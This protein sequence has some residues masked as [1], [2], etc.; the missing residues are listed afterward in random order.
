MTVMTWFS[1]NI[2][3][4]VRHHN[5]SAPNS[6]PVTWG[7]WLSNLSS[8][9]LG[10][11]SWGSPLFLWGLFWRKGQVRDFTSRF[12][13]V[14]Q[15]LNLGVEKVRFSP[16]WRWPVP[17]RGR[18]SF[19][20]LFWLFRVRFVSDSRNQRKVWKVFVSHT[21]WNLPP[22]AIERPLIQRGGQL[23]RHVFFLE[24]VL[25]LNHPESAKDHYRLG[26]P[27]D[28]SVILGVS[29]PYLHGLKASYKNLADQRGAR[30]DYKWFSQKNV[31]QQCISK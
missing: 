16:S 15:I 19:R 6:T 30:A 27:R 26:A 9:E 28:G 13:C 3:P 17:F 14:S 7:G 8:G 4:F 1:S 11:K 23:G 24:M 18:A 25:H 22:D 29:F 10:Q 20:G 5:S 21:F 31:M 2:K 12:A